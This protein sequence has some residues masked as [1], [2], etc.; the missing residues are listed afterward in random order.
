MEIRSSISSKDN[1][2]F[3]FYKRNPPELQF[4]MRKLSKGLV[5]PSRRANVRV[6]GR[7]GGGGGLLVGGV[8]YGHSDRMFS[9]RMTSTNVNRPGWNLLNYQLLK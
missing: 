2:S 3:A 5:P 9:K 1:Q 4:I 6:G 8:V 7:G